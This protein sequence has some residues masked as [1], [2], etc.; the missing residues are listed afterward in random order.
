MY[1][2]V[3]SGPDPDDDAAAGG[4]V[5]VA[6][7]RCGIDRVLDPPMVAFAGLVNQEDELPRPRADHT[8]AHDAAVFSGCAEAAGGESQQRCCCRGPAAPRRLGAI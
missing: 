4:A 5:A 3:H 2:P 6:R 7:G 8:A 1:L